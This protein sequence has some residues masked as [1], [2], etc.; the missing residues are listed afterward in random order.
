MKKD[1][2]PARKR[3]KLITMDA[4]LTTGPETAL[5]QKIREESVAHSDRILELVQER[6]S[7]VD[8]GRIIAAMDAIRAASR[9]AC[10]A[11]T[12]PH[13]VE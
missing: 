11:I 12:L 13:I 4:T 6:A 7:R 3:V 1:L 2:T 8:I 5:I 9:D 10:D